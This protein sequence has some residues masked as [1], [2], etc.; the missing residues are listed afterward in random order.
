MLELPSVRHWKSM[1]RHATSR[2]STSRPGACRELPASG[3][4]DQVVA[5]QRKQA[6]LEIQLGR[7]STRGRVTP[8][9]PRSRCWRWQQRTTCWG[10]HAAGWEFTGRSRGPSHQAVTLAPDNQLPE[11]AARSHLSWQS[12]CQRGELEQRT[13]I[14]EKHQL[15]HSA[16]RSFGGVGPQ[17]PGL[18]CPPHRRHG[19]GT[20]SYS[21]RAGAGRSAR[22]LVAAAVSVQHR[23]EIA[24]AEGE[25]QEAEMWLKS[26]LAEAEERGNQHR[27]EHPRESE[28]GGR[29]ARR[30]G[31]GACSARNG[32]RRSS[33]LRALHL[34]TQIDLWLAELYLKRGERTAA[35]EALSRAELRLSAANARACWSGQRASGQAA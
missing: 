5:G 12:A 8:G 33:T 23:G 10:G 13:G 1:R 32:L 34:Q 2:H 16:G 18:P 22:P 17:Q 25:T 31:R 26:A 35:A 15:A 24:L 29:G 9:I 30:F 20:G 21:D 6:E 27:R 11:I 28:P 19:Y 4:G 3:Q 7:I 14:P